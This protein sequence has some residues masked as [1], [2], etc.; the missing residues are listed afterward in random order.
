MLHNNLNELGVG[1]TRGQHICPRAQHE[2]AHAG[3]IRLA[4]SERET[5]QS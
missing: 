1:I 4:G 5:T 3:V 2:A